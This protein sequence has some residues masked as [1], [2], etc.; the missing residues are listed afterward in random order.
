VDGLRRADLADDP[1]EQFRRWFVEW[2]ATGPKE[3]TA[4]AL[5]TADAAGRPS[6][7]FVLLKGVDHGFVLYTNYQSRKGAELAANPQGALCFGWLELERQ[8]RVVGP[9][10]QVDPAESDAYFAT[11]P[12]GSQW[13]AWA[14]DQSRPISGRE[15]LEARWADAEARY[16]GSV[17]RPPHWGGY[18]LLPDEIE[19]WQG[20][21]S[22]LHDRFGYRR[23]AEGWDVT[24]LMP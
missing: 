9:V 1:L 5:A 8:V 14:S 20:R 11:R 24:R 3:P 22:R 10:E 19:F 13:G 16:G 23:T 17:P 18:R 6:V 2:E 15:E 4:V 12:P 7:R 21:P